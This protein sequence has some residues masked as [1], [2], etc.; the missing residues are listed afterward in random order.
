MECNV[1]VL[2]FYNV[3]EEFKRYKDARIKKY[4]SY[5]VEKCI[6]RHQNNVIN[7]NKNYNVFLVKL[8]LEILPKRERFLSIVLPM[9]DWE[10]Y[11]EVFHE[12]AKRWQ[13]Y[14]QKLITGMHI[15]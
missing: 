7:F 3:Y 1:S 14:P 9:L 11:E 12:L 4:Q 5:N 10:V 2:F 13:Q 8:L 15:L 6:W